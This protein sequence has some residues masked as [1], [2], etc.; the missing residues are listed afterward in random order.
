M[1]G[2]DI[3]EPRKTQH[4]KQFA[5]LSESGKHDVLLLVNALYDGQHSEEDCWRKALGT[6]GE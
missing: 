2:Y 3:T 5:S 6:V 1:L 4:R